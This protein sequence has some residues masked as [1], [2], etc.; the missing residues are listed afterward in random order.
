MYSLY[1]LI[2]LLGCVYVSYGGDVLGYVK[3][4]IVI[5]VYSFIGLYSLIEVGVVIGKGVVICVYL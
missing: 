5:G 4:L 2:W 3:V 1:C